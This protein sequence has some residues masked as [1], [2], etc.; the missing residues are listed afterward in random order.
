MADEER[1]RWRDAH[2]NALAALRMIRETI[3]TMRPPGAIPSRDIVLIE[4]GP[5]PVHEERPSSK[6][7]DG[8]CRERRHETVDVMQALYDSEITVRTEPDGCWDNGCRALRQQ[9]ERFQGAD[10]SRRHMGRVDD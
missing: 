7:C 2:Q 1:E 3:E 9:Q 10:R 6:C 5:E 8:F 4:H